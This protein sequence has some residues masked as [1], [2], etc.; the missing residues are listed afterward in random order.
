MVSLL[1]RVSPRACTWAKVAQAGLLSNRA[2]GT[3]KCNFPMKSRFA[4]WLR[5]INKQITLERQGGHHAV[6]IDPQSR[7][8]RL[9]WRDT[10]EHRRRCPD[11]VARW[12][13]RRRQ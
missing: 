13:Y 5:N 2:H 3:A 11:Q 12:N 1:M 4:T 8:R 6:Q 9:G 10:V 7:A